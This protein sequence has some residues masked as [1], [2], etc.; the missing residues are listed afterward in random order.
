MRRASAVT[1]VSPP[2]WPAPEQG[3]T[4]PLGWEPDAAW[5]P[6]PEGWQFWQ[7]VASPAA[8]A[9]PWARRLR[10]RWVAVA[11]VLLVVAGAGGAVIAQRDAER[12]AELRATRAAVAQEREAQAE[13][14]AALQRE[15][16]A[17]R[18]EAARA[19][20]AATA[21]AAASAAAEEQRAAEKAAADAAAATKA[22]AQRAARDAE[23][24]QAAAWGGGDAEF[25]NRAAAPDGEIPPFPTRLGRYR[26]VDTRTETVRAFDGS[27]WSTV[28]EFGNTM[29]GCDGSWSLV[30]WRAVNE[31]AVVEATHGYDPA[32]D[33][34]LAEA[35]DGNAGWMAM[36]GCEQP[37]FRL[38][39]SSDGSTLTDIVV[40]V[41][42]WA[43]GT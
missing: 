8:R 36:S 22:A 6:A 30:R 9:R 19:A 28:F 29:N 17:A 27:D 32:G 11:A 37:G 10:S 4:P 34:P 2:G 39:G 16:A 31:N 14:L 12:A 41:Q 40:D 26:L 3:W 13:A 24:R 33:Y 35:V 42:T 23:A 7:P 1:W 43:A 38:R 15:A 25:L 21:A 5:P 20:E 18:A